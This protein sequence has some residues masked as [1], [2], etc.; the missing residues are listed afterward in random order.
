MMTTMIPD[1]KDWTWVLQQPCPECGFDASA[2]AVADVGP[3]VRS[4]IP[5]WQAALGRADAR[6]RPDASTWSTL[7]YGAHVRDVFRIFDERLALMLTQ[8]EP[9]FPNWDQDATALE[10][11]YAAQDPAVVA[12]ELAAA[13]TAIAARFDAVPA[14]AYGRTGLRSNGSAFTVDTLAAYF[15]HDVAHHLH[16]VRRQA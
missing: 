15:W 5:R 16:D 4:S 14:T 9:T 11:R 8:E 7:E 12:D 6:E 3:L 10:E 13:G 1:T 2:I